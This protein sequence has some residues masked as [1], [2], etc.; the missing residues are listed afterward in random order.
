MTM[1]KYIAKRG[2]MYVAVITTTKKDA[3]KRRS[4]DQLRNF[5]C[6]SIQKHKTVV[7]MRVTY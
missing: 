2:N 3:E 6:S 7:E 1:Y 5:K 4:M